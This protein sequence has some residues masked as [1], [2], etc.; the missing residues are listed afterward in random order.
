MMIPFVFISYFTGNE[1]IPGDLELAE[2]L[3]SKLNE[4]F[5]SEAC[6]LGPRVRRDAIAIP[7]HLAQ[8]IESAHY[9]VLICPKI[10]WIDQKNN[11]QI[12]KS[13][14]VDQEIGYAYS[15]ARTGD[16]RIIAIYREEDWKDLEGFIS[17]GS[18]H[19]ARHFKLDENSPE[20]TWSEVIAFIRQ[21]RWFPLEIVGVEYD[22]GGQPKP[23]ENVYEYDIKCRVILENKSLNVLKDTTL[24]FIAPQSNV[25]SP[26]T[27]M[28]PGY[29]KDIAIIEFYHPLLMRQDVPSKIHKT[30]K[31][32]MPVSI[33][34]RTTPAEIEK[35][36]NLENEQSSGFFRRTYFLNRLPPL[37]RIELPFHIKLYTKN[38]DFCEAHL[39]LYLQLPRFGYW[40]CEILVRT[41]TELPSERLKIHQIGNARIS[42]QDLV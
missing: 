37:S 13:A 22:D 12:K 21:D 27:D 35:L 30:S 29:Q 16:L 32:S 26:Q 17:K 39:G 14:W 15:R 31:E 33:L 20:R 7:E 19:L 41:Q 9:F 42:V 5:G 3:K 25:P 11:I 1:K 10:D 36:L 2:S 28:V 6:E 38:Q 40:L 4:E 18:H 34:S 23:A 24:D 8:M